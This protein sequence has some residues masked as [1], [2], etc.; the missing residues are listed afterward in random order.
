MRICDTPEMNAMWEKIEPYLVFEGMEVRLRE[1]TPQEI[2]ELDE[3][4]TELYRKRRKEAEDWLR[5]VK[6]ELLP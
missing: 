5:N 3:K 4:Y 2:R 6:V 1:D